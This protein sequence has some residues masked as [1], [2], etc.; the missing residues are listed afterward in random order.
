MYTWVPVYEAI[1]RKL[2]EFESRQK[3]LINVLKEI[4]I[5][6]SNDQASTGPIE[7]DEIDPFTFLNFI[8]KHGAEKR[9]SLVNSV[10]AKLNIGGRASDTNGIPSV[11]PMNV[12]MFPS[13][14]E[15]DAETIPVLW[16]LFKQAFDGKL[17]SGDFEK[18]QN[19]K[20]MGNPKIT[21]AIF[22]ANPHAFLPVNKQT[23]DYFRKNGINPDFSDLT[24]YLQVIR[25][26]QEKFK[27]PNYQVSY[28]GWVKTNEG[29]IILSEPVPSVINPMSHRELID[30]KIASYKTT[31]NSLNTILYGP[32]GTGKTYNTIAEAV[33]IVDNKFYQEF[34][35]NRERLQRRFN[36]LLIKDWEKLEGQ[37]SFCT[38]HQSFSYEDFVEGIKPLKPENGDTMIKYGI[39]DGIFKKICRLADASNNAQQL[40]KENL[41]S[42]SSEEFERALFYK[43]SLGDSNREED[44]EIYEFCINNG[45]I[46]IGFGE[47]IDFSGK[48]EVEVEKLVKKE[49]LD[50]Y[51]AQAV[52]YF[53]NYLKVGNYVVISFGNNYIRA[54]GKVT[55]EYEFKPDVEI[56]Y[57]HFRKVEWIF[58]EVE[59]PVTE[60][61]KKNLMQQTIYKLRNESL[62]PSF[63]VSNK[64]GSQIRAEQK[65]FVLVIDEINRGNVSAVFGELITLVESSKRTGKPEALEVVLPY[66]KEKFSVP[67]NVHIIGTMNTADRS[68]ESLD[69]ALRRRFSFREMSPRPDLIEKAGKS[70]GLVV[71]INLVNLL[72]K[73]NERIEK[74][75]DKD[76]R[77]GHSY[78][79][80]VGSKEELE[81]AFQDKV[82]PLLEEY[83][84]GDFGKIGLVLGSSFV[85]RKEVS[86]FN[87]A[88]FADYDTQSEQDLREKVVYKIKPRTAWDYKSI[89]E[90]NGNL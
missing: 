78:F 20:G 74:L 45:F 12:W 79:L 64:N 31:S 15:R 34:W 22:T 44:K 29:G 51:T 61:Y 65:N 70:K 66:S 1:S 87:F 63:F 46:S 80:E 27:K 69:T 17:D 71:G 2:L 73:V 58:K 62:I 54:L 19:I 72:T 81:L 26:V 60:F 77:I 10:A 59:I 7:L 33:K 43:V 9:L 52:N 85:E 86:D 14:F 84:F 68:I 35:E 56:R 39:E 57:K 13:K 48:D 3:E 28:E 4:G 90:A 30:S 25:E 50:P 16:R 21:G 18:A 47:D 88:H 67:E 42:L 41:V 32:P 6:V 23:A 5:D 38:F 8:N 36:E 37:I 76:H 40:A 24:G 11:F 55:G 75:I 83:F 82:I 89:Y 53:K 49:K